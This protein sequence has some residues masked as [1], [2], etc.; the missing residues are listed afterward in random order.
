MLKSTERSVIL[1]DHKPLTYFLES[2]VLDGIYARWASELRC[3]GIDIEW[4]PGKRNEVADALSRTIFPDPDSGTPPVEEFGELI[5]DKYGEP[6]WIWKD[7][8]GGYEEL[9]RKMADPLRLESINELFR[10]GYN[11][12]G[13]LKKDG[14]VSNLGEAHV[15]KPHEKYVCSEWYQDIV[16]YLVGGFFPEECITKV[17]RSSLRR[18]SSNYVISSD[19]ELYYDLR[20]VRKR[21]IV[22]DEVA[23][24]LRLAHDQGGHFSQ[25]I[26]LR[27][28]REVYWPRMAIDVKDY[29]LGC[30]VCAKFGTAIRSQATARVMVGEP[31]ELLG[32]D[33]IGPFP[34]FLDTSERWILLAV[35]YFSR[36]VWA[37][38]VERNDSDTVIKFL[39]TA[40]FDKFGIPVGLY[41][42]PGPHFG[43]KTRKFAESCGTIWC[44][45][46]VAAKGAVGMV[47]KAVDVLQRVL[48]KVSPDPK[49]WA[50]KVPRAVL[51]VNKREIAHLSYSPSEILLGFN[52]LGSLEIKYSVHRR[53]ELI[54]AMGADLVDLLPKDEEHANQVIDFIIRRTSVR[55]KAGKRSE[56]FK[57]RAAERHD[58]GIRGA[59]SYAPGDLV[60]L[61]DHQQ[62]GRKL[63]PTWRGP[64]VVVGFGGDM[65]KS[66]RLR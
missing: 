14:L 39:R 2:S 53:Q 49:K 21:C 36:Y 31:M 20:G 10:N 15:R 41:M 32:I 18:K 43:E 37:E 54:E 12:N 66:Y 27:K 57:D 59:S 47:E 38:A 58:L 35:D 44:N 19:G 48:K 51:E 25:V 5:R 28:L 4:I 52:P 22:R 24:V 11:T 64:F 56:M 34:K 6:L 61:Y 63:R 1:T 46:P 13:L 45:S 65:G 30:L 8:K 26:T 23:E 42:D 62:A 40:I 29:I 50:E 9:I 7:G 55:R 33:F 17:Q 3:L 16:N 60:M